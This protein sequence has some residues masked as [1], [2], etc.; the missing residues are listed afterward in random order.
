MINGEKAQKRQ[1]TIP[2]NSRQRSQKPQQAHDRRPP[3]NEKQMQNICFFSNKFLI[4]ISVQGSSA[5]YLQGQ[6]PLLKDVVLHLVNL[7]HLIVLQNALIEIKVH[8]ALELYTE[9][10]TQQP[11]ARRFRPCLN[12]PIA[13]LSPLRASS[14]RPARRTYIEMNVHAFL[15]THNLLHNNLLL[16]AC[17]LAEIA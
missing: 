13:P 17:V 5:C 2:Q 1:S 4:I 7:L 16:V 12:C 11:F 6:I 9:P 15:S 8:A 3:L 14:H 10:F